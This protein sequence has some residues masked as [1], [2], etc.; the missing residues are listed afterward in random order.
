MA[1][2]SL[3]GA[4]SEN[5]G[6]EGRGPSDVTIVVG[7]AWAA[8]VVLVAGA[9]AANVAFVGLGSSFEYPDILDE[10][11][12]DIVQLFD[13]TRATTMAWFALLA[14]GA[15]LL[16]PG[17]VLLGALGRGRPA[18]WSVWAGVAAGVV[19]LIGLSRWFVLVP[20]YVDR[21][22]DPGASAA[23]R[24]GAI[25]DFETAHD[26]LGT[27]VGETLGYTLTAAWTILVVLAFPKAATWWRVSGAA[28]SV[29][30]LLGVLVPLG[31][32]GT[33]LANFIGYVLWSLWLIALGVLLVRGHLTDARARSDAPRSSSVAT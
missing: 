23:S 6:L 2:H 16:I 9:V 29:L 26:V 28:T 21:A 7:R 32:P 27:V 1:S 20:G 15:A 10:P 30:I 33:D 31:V 5:A 8:A 4:D 24:A 18:K 17:A 11:T 25:S 22:L 13:D 12:Q 3:R 19:Q 14:F